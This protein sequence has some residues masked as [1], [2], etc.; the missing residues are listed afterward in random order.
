MKKILAAFVCA[1]SCWAT[2][3]AAHP[4]VSDDSGTQG[5]TGYQFE[6]NA[7]ATRHERDDAV[8]RSRLASA[9]L[10]YGVTDRMDFALTVPYLR[11]A[12]SDSPA[13][14]G[15]GDMQLGVKWRFLEE[16]GWS[17]AWKQHF[18]FPS[19]DQ[20]RG[21]GNGR[22]GIGA[23]ILAAYQHDKLQWLVNAGYAYNGNAVGARSNLW[24]VSS[25]VLWQ[26]KPTVKA[27]LDVGA[28]RNTDRNENR[29]PAFAI[30]G[31]IFSLTEKLDID[32]GMR[33]GLN[34]AEMDY[35]AGAGVTLRW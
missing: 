18:I 5:K 20:R 14:R 6:A 23:G 10:T 11:L 31:V 19:G 8:S 9:T 35:A 28:Y 34:K 26:I 17:V 15:I 29:D 1:V 3:F 7:D 30:I 16:N 4:L 21:L 33:K 2:C 24:N 25:A 12:P 22:A 27:V 32:F 13:S